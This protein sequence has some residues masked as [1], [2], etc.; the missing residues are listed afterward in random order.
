MEFIFGE[1]SN[2]NFICKSNRFCN[3]ELIYISFKNERV[4]VYICASGTF[5]RLHQNMS[6]GKAFIKNI[7][8]SNL[9]YSEL[10]P[11]SL[12]SVYISLGGDDT[13]FSNDLFREAFE[14][15]IRSIT[16]IQSYVNGINNTSS[17]SGFSPVRFYAKM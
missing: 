2:I 12:D 4:Y 8:N 14:D 13:F 1:S 6:L 10:L 16:P 17:R 7:R 11:E 9:F 5:K 15:I 3:F